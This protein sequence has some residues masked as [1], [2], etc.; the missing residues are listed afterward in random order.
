MK[1]LHFEDNGF[2]SRKIRDVLEECGNHNI[3][4]VTTLNA[5]LEKINRSIEEGR[6]FDL[7]ITDMNYPVSWSQ[8]RG[9]DLSGNLLIKYL[10]ENN[11][12]IPIILCSS[13]NYKDPQIYGAVHYSE[14][15]DW[16][17]ELKK[18]VMAL[19]A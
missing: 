16:E 17:N 18:L 2:K 10:K 1:I 4:L 3:E 15:S 14:R 9:D 5:G 13:V 8:K 7:I 12:D 11:I 6:S 19:N